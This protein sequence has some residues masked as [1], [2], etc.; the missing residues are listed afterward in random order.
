MVIDRRDKAAR[1]LLLRLAG[2]KT[3]LLAA[4]DIGP[5]P[6]AQGPS[7][8][9]SESP[10]AASAETLMGFNAAK[11]GLPEPSETGATLAEVATI[12]LWRSKRIALVLEG[13]SLNPLI[14]RGLEVVLWPLSP[15]GQEEAVKKLASL[16]N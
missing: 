3:Q 4:T 1:S 14:D 7:S 5:L 11:L 8:D 6:S 12:A 13:T 10:T 2:V 9:S 15:S 16:L